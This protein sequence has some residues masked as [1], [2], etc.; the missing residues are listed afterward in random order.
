MKSYLRTLFALGSCV[1]FLMTIAASAEDVRLSQT[2]A[3]AEVANAGLQRLTSDQIAILDALVRRDMA[4]NSRVAS[5]KETRAARFSQR[6]SAD[7][8]KN[9]GLT[10]LTSDQLARLDDYVAR[11]SAPADASVSSGAAGSSGNSVVSAT[12]LRRAPEIHGM[13]SLMYGVGSGGYSERG[14]AMVLSYEDPSGFALAVGYSEVRTKGGYGYLTGDCR[15]RFYGG[16][17]LIDGLTDPLGGRSFDRAEVALFTRGHRDGE[18]V[19]LRR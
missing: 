1:T 9:S 10:L 18:S 11:L 6:L 8:R 16:P 19:F 3:P 17:G 15:D 12:I 5:T 14:G 13:I 4:A 7:E 2:L